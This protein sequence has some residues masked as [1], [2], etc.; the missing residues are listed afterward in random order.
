MPFCVFLFLATG[1]VSAQRLPQT[2]LCAVP[3]GLREKE[4]KS[5]TKAKR[6]TK[7]SINDRLSMSVENRQYVGEDM[8]DETDGAED[9]TGRIIE[10]KRITK[11][12][13]IK[14]KSGERQ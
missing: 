11:A 1:F 7:L 6:L 13:K 10:I 5:K 12:G 3:T 14:Q 9:E 8:D 4:H 2:G